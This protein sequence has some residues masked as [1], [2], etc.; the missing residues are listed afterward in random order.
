MNALG[1]RVMSDLKWPTAIS[2]GIILSSGIL[3]SSVLMNSNVTVN[4]SNPAEE[5]VNSGLNFST[6]PSGKT[7]TDVPF[8][9]S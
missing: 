7:L 2:I 5:V 3:N 8:M 9:V 1:S 6:T 4:I